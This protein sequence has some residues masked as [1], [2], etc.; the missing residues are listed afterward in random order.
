MSDLLSSIGFGGYKETSREA[1]KKSSERV[2]EMK[3]KILSY[4]KSV[5]ENGA[6]DEEMDIHLGT[7]ATRSNRPTRLAL[8]ES[9]L[10][11]DSKERRE[12]SSGSKAIV[13]VLT[14]EDEVQAQKN[15][16][17]IE[18]Y[19]KKVK[20]RLSTLTHEQLKALDDLMDYWESDD[21]EPSE[22]NSDWYLDDLGDNPSGY[23]SSNG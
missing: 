20:R 2:S 18:S 3:K 15:L 23:D 9:G 19:R 16:M 1:Y 4:L 11:R 14:P 17:D 8:V 21:D 7:T 6:T 12:T 5:G 10:V 22:E 13:W